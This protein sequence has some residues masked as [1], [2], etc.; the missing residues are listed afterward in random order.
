METGTRRKREVKMVGVE[1]VE[2]IRAQRVKPPKSLVES[3]KKH[4]V[5]EPIV[6]R[7]QGDGYAVLDGR[8]RYWAAVEAGL[9]EIPVRVVE[10]GKREERLEKILTAQL[11]KTENPIEEARIIKEL[12]NRG[13]SLEEIARLTGK[14]KGFLSKRLAL[15]S[16]IP[17]LFKML[18]KGQISPS[19]G[20]R[21]GRHPEKEQWSFYRWA[22]TNGF[23]LKSYEEWRSRLN[24]EKAAESFG[25]GWEELIGGA[26]TLVQ[27]KGSVDSFAA[28]KNRVAGKVLKARDFKELKRALEEG[29]TLIPDEI[30]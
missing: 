3:V 17:P 9:E 23:N 4:G 11:L 26:L 28:L 18:A 10:S 6:V 30:G 21:I 13:K 7:P 15:L 12:Q 1:R 25:D 22:K 16:L 5:I 14:T 27:E 20:Y 29:L 19:L 8:K 2:K 24:S